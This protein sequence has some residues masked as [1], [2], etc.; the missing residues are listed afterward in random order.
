MGT[1]ERGPGRATE[2]AMA[3]VIQERTVADSFIDALV[4]HDFDAIRECLQPNVRFRAL[5]PGA[6]WAHLG[7]ESALATLRH[8]FADETYDLNC[9]S[10][11]QIGDRT[12][13]AYRFNLATDE[14]P[15][16][17]EQQAYCAIESGKI[18]DISIIC[19]GFRPLPDA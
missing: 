6:T 3:T 10:I 9:A 15:R 16:L 12:R 8:W 14:G 4:A 7:V 2:D 5:T 19:T 17:V 18:A 11:D 1:G 13:I